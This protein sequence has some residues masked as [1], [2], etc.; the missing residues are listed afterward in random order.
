MDLGSL[1]IWCKTIGADFPGLWYLL[2]D[3][4]S[5]GQSL[6]QLLLK[7]VVVAVFS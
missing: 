7:A 6:G 5:V 1:S 2:P 4:L 3:T